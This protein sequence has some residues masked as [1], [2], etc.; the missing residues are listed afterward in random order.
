LLAGKINCELNLPNAF[1]LK[2]ELS[3]NQ[4]RNRQLKVVDKHAEELKFAGSTF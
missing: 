2:V 3:E 1:A 4:E